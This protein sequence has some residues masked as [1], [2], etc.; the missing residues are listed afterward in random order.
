MCSLRL[1]FLSF[2][3]QAGDFGA[4]AGGAAAGTMDSEG[5]CRDTFAVITNTN[6]ANTPV[7]CGQN[8]GQHSKL[9]TIKQYSSIPKVSDQKLLIFQSIYQQFAAL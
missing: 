5:A 4:A 3:I 2:N 8:E 9:L 1:D 6:G 7:I